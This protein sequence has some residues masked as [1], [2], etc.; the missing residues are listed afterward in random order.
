M[1]SKCAD[2]DY[3]TR[4]GECILGR[5]PRKCTTTEARKGVGFSRRA[6]VLV[7]S[8]NVFLLSALAF[9]LVLGFVGGIAYTCR[10]QFCSFCHEM[11]ADIRA[12][13][14]SNHRNVN[15]ISCHV[16]PGLIALLKDKMTVAPKSLIL[17]ITGNYE[18]PINKE[19]KLAKDISDESCLQCHTLK[20]ITPSQGLKIDHEA[21]SKLGMNCTKCHNRVAHEIKGYENFLTEESCFSCHNGKVLKN[22]CI[23]CH[24]EGFLQKKKRAQ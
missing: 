10:P 15:C 8:R 16:E 20:N 13:K 23:I 18:K 24:T 1:V 6:F 17:K 19:S 14:E 11:E 5:D 22:D 9:F 21:H 3:Q 7:I 12:W 4:S 2:C